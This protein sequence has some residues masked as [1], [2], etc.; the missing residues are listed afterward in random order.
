MMVRASEAETSFIE[1][2]LK[3]FGRNYADMDDE[4]SAGELY[5]DSL[6]VDKKFRGKGIAKLLLEAT[7]EKGRR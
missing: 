4:T 6:C 2:A 7:I 3:A 1:R 5:I